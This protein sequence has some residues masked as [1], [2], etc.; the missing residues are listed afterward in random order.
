MFYPLNVLVPH[1]L[2]GFKPCISF[3]IRDMA[4]LTFHMMGVQKRF[5]KGVPKGISWKHLSCVY[6]TYKLP[7]I[8]NNMH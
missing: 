3:E 4:I 5:K 2:L 8:T 7:P 6:L 1:R